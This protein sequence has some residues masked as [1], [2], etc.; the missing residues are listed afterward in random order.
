MGRKKFLGLREM[1]LKSKPFK[2]NVLSKHV[3]ELNGDHS[4]KYYKYML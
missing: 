1:D 2:E 3:L 4:F